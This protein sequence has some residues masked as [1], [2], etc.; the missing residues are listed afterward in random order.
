[1]G[2]YINE[3]TTEDNV[4]IDENYSGI[5]GCFQII[6]DCIH[7]ENVMFESLFDNDYREALNETEDP[8]DLGVIYKIANFL[9]ESIEILISKISSIIDA[10]SSKLDPKRSKELRKLAD[11]LP[12]KLDI[13]NN[14][15]QQL[16]VK[17]IDTK[18]NISWLENKFINK[19]DIL[20]VLD[21]SNYRYEIYKDPSIE[22][23]TGK[24]KDDLQ[25]AV[26]GV[27][28]IK[29]FGDIDDY[30][31]VEDWTM[32]RLLRNLKEPCYVI[33]KT[34]KDLREIKKLGTQSLSKQKKEIKRDYIDSKKL[35]SYKS[36]NDIKIM[37]DVVK[38]LQR[39]FPVCI[40]KYMKAATETY[41]A[42]LYCLKYLTNDEV[43][44]DSYLEESIN[45]EVDYDF[46]IL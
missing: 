19:S 13:N 22:K 34:F 27:G 5:M 35:N 8:S 21:L 36:T 9:F 7:N 31:T 28:G 32:N 3:S 41:K 6:S 12:A 25:E 14:K 24:I 17:F 45:Y 46:G 15:V 33:D 37:L 10:F 26:F 2:M 20:D 18:I 23:L 1:M 30:D 44:N 16:K 43:V 40:S 4:C 38:V 39:Q 29:W 11:K 42:Y